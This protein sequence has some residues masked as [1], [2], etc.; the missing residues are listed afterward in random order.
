MLI[1]NTDL[2]SGHLWYFWAILYDLIIFYLADKWRLTKWLRYVTPLLL[3][4][5]FVFNYTPFP[6]YWV[7]NFLFMGLPSMMIG[8]C[9]RENNDKTI[10]FL[11]NE[12]YLWI[13]TFVFTFLSYGEMWLLGSLSSDNSDIGWRDMYVFSI[14]MFL[15]CFYWALRHPNIGEGSWTATIG[16]QYSA[17]IYIFHVLVGTVLGYIV[18]KDGSLFTTAIYPFLVF[19]ISLCISWFFV[20][21]LQGLRKV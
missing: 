6:N 14:P 3:L 15:P 20:C 1:F 18:D 5:L 2:F 19:G 7:R 4:V 11:S 10:R 8:R 16:R 13:Y 12:R 17:Y 9:I 21:L